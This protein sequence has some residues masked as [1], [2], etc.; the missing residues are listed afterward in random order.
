MLS[1]SE[2]AQVTGGTWLVPPEVSQHKGVGSWSDDSRKLSDGML[3]LA[4]KGEL[5]DGHK[6]L[7]NAVAAGASAVLVEDRP[8][9]EFLTELHGRGV[10]CLQCASSLAAYQQLALW[11][12]RQFPSVKVLAITGSCGKTST[13]EMCAAILEQ[14]WPGG[15]LKT[16]GSTN[17]HFGV[18]RNLLRIDDATR[19]AVI[20]MGTNHP[21]EIANL[22]S[23]APP[24]VGVVCNI[25]HAHLEFFHDLEGV[26]REKGDL[27]AGTL[28][29]GIA[30]YPLEAVGVQTLREKAG[31][32]KQM[33]FGESVQAAVSYQYLGYQDGKFH[34]RLEWRDSG[35]SREVAWNLGG[36][37]MAANAACAAAA[38]T[39]LGC[40]PDEVASGLTV[41]Q[42]PGQR[43]EITEVAGVHWVNDAFNA[44]PDSMK[45]ALD[46][47]AEVVPADAPAV[48]VLGDMLELG[49]GSQV[50]HIEALHFAR[51]KCPRAQL[52]TVGPLMRAAAA[53]VDAAIQSV[54]NADE[55]AAQLPAL[56]QPG[57]WIL[58]KSSHGIGLAKLV[59]VT[60]L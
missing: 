2:L 7:A 53:E 38:A 35:E 32:R 33:T 44:N 57:T 49:A 60:K 42:L 36:V 3:F 17:N 16:I 58:L 5:T 8:S 23:L 19:V 41:C 9:D 15:V 6:Y 26:A 48:L 34:L 13:K 39:A 10:P 31:A 21:G 47:F 28:P 1:F 11:H 51:R 59:P 55:M 46:W 56:A 27:L 29:E 54:A 30:V 43:L 22:V 24:D 40:T 52:W 4:I 14:H 20:E 45:A 50:S 25:G 12:R 18:P 37:H